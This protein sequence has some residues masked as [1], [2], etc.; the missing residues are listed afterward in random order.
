VAQILNEWEAQVLQYLPQ[1]SELIIE[2]ASDD[3]TDAAIQIWISNHKAYAVRFFHREQ[4]DGYFNAVY[5]LYMNARC[6]YVFISD[7]DGQYV[8]SDFWKIVPYMNDYD[9]V[10][11]VK[12]HR[13][14]PGYRIWASF[15]FNKVSQILF[16]HSFRDINSAHRLIKR[17]VVIQIL[18]HICRMR[19]LLNAELLL[20]L[21]AGGFKIKEIDIDHRPRLEGTSKGL[22]AATYVKESWGALRGLIQ[23]KSDLKSA[24]I[25]RLH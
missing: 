11:G 22:P 7:A 2:D 17:E 21:Y 5:R 16:H 14:D 24:P 8:P 19:V 20:R 12:T 10:H 6:P 1:G 4:R 25:Y 3:G 9:M 18:P 15:I 13:N 23:L